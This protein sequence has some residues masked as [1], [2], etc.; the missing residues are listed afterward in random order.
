MA[1]RTIPIYVADEYIKGGGVPVGATGSHHDVILRITFSEL[2]DGL[3]KQIQWVDSLGENRTQTLVTADLLVPGT[4]NTYDIEIPAEPKA[5]AGEM[6]MTIKGAEVEN[7][8]EKR[9]TMSAS[10]TF[11]VLESDWSAEANEASD[12]N[13]TKAEQLQAEIDTI[14]A[15]ISDA[16]D[17]AGDA[18]D[19]AL[20]AQGYADDAKDYADDAKDYADQ[21]AGAADQAVLAQS[22]AVGGTGTRAGENTNNAKYW[23]DCA[24]GAASGGVTSFNGRFG[25]VSAESGDY[26]AAQVGADPSGSAAAV[27]S[28]LD[29]HTGNTSNPHSVT[30]TQAGAVPVAGGTM[31][32]ALTLSGAPSADLH[33]ATKKYV[34]D[35][36]AGIDFPVDSVAGKTGAVTLDPADAGLEDAVLRN[37]THTKTADPF[38]VFHASERSGGGDFSQPY[39]FCTD[40]ETIVAACTATGGFIFYSTDNGETF[41]QS[42]MTAFGGMAGTF[43]TASIIHDGNQFIVFGGTS[44]SSGSASNYIFTSPDGSVWSQVTATG[45]GTGSAVGMAYGNGVYVCTKYSS[46]GVVYYSSDLV[47]WASATVKSAEYAVKH[48]KFANNVFLAALVYMGTTFIYKSSNGSSWT[49]TGMSMQGSSN[50]REF[51]VVYGGGYYV[52]VTGTKLY[53]TTNLTSATSI[54]IGAS[55]PANALYADG[56]F[57]ITSASAVY[58]ATDPDSAGNWSSLPMNDGISTQCNTMVYS[59]EADRFVYASSANALAIK[60]TQTEY[61]DVLTFTDVAGAALAIPN[62]K[63]AVG[64]YVGDGTSGQADYNSLTIGFTPKI[65]FIHGVGA[66]GG[67]GILNVASTVGASYVG[68]N[69]SDD[70]TAMSGFYACALTVEATS[71]VVRWYSEAS[72]NGARAQL[73]TNSAVYT[74]LAIG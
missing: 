60:Y 35:E 42:D 73:N 21:A 10:C 17:A 53:V 4:L 51:D 38:S 52:F 19:S 13:T 69:S 22:W 32:G 54:T 55:N 50:V 23:S 9:A 18:A 74:Y 36:I 67:L 40:G 41:Q 30:A 5:V 6:L 26:T 48:V 71:T 34:D 49:N 61:D 65:V 62:A 39:M 16:R 8:L 63:I 28:N 68:D 66:A 11:P 14:L 43:L 56:K 15:T 33:A 59:S 47:T 45:I 1:T 29:T 64:S 7:D 58:Y 25:A 72:S 70:G 20:E 12:V 27:Q 3:A 37:I 46:Y 2:W 31:T 44:L 57:W 24:Q